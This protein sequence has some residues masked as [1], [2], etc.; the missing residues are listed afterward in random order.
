[1]QQEYGR[2]VDV[3][4][5]G[6]IT[7][8]VM[9]G[10]LPFFNNVLHKLYRQIVERDLNFPE[11]PW[12]RISKGIQDFILRVLQIRPGERPNAE[13]ALKHPWLYDNSSSALTDITNAS[14]FGALQTSPTSSPN[15]LQH[16]RKTG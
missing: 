3:W 13:E 6:V 10:S 8:I 7:F 2:E 14:S 1:M 5:C 16:A 15:P 4:A 12:K 11:Q 9:S